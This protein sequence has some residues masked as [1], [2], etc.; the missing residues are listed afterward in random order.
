MNS[1]RLLGLIAVGLLTALPLTASA[2]TKADSIEEHH[3]I[4]AD[5][6]IDSNDWNALEADLDADGELDLAIGLPSAEA[7]RGRIV[8]LF[9]PIRDWPSLISLHAPSG[10]RHATIAGEWPGDRF[11]A[12]LAILPPAPERSKAALLVGAPGTRPPAGSDASGSIY[13][14]TMQPE[15][16]LSSLADLDGHDGTRLLAADP[17]SG[18][19]RQLL[20]IEPDGMVLGRL[21]QAPHSLR[22]DGLPSPLGASHRIGDRSNRSATPLGRLTD[23]LPA[24]QRSFSAPDVEVQGLRSGRSLRA[25]F[26][27]E[28]NQTRLILS[29]E[30]LQGSVPLIN[31][32]DGIA[33]QFV[34][35]GTSLNLDFIISDPS[36]PADQLTVQVQVDPQSPL[37]NP[38]TV[39][40]LGT[41][42]FRTLVIE[43]F[44][45]LPDGSTPVTVQVSNPLGQLT[46]APFAL[47]VIGTSV[48]EINGGLGLT[49]ETVV[50]GDTLVKFFTADDLLFFP[51]QLTYSATSSNPAL[52]PPTSI[53]LDGDGPDRVITIPTDA[54]SNGQSLITVQVSNP[55]AESTSADFLLTVG[56]PAVGPR[57]NGG[58][59]IPARSVTAGQTL[60]VAFQISDPLE[61]AASLGVSASSDDQTL[62]P[63]N[64]LQILGIGANRVLRIPTSSTATGTV[65]LTLVV[66][67]SQGLSSSASF[68][69]SILQRSRP[70]LNFNLT[71]PVETAQPGDVV[72]WNLSVGDLVDPPS[73]LRLE[74][75]SLTPALL[76]DS[77]LALFGSS[78]SRLLRATVPLGSAAGDARIGLRLTNTAGLQSTDEIELIIDVPP[79]PIINDGEPLPDQALPPGQTTEIDLPILD[80]DG[81]PGVFEVLVFSLDQ[82]VLPDEALRLIEDGDDL[83]LEIDTSLGLPGTTRIVIEARDPEGGV[84][85]TSFELTIAADLTELELESEAVD[86]QF[87]DQRFFEIRVRNRGDFPA[88][89]LDLR[90]NSDG[91]I[92]LLSTVSRASGCS[93]D[94]QNAVRCEDRVGSGWQCSGGSL[95]RRCRLESLEVDGE[96]RLLLG[97]RRG[98]DGDVLLEADASNAGTVSLGLEG[99][100]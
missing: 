26:D 44:P 81:L 12:D 72:E 99:E 63:D 21:D 66:S 6:R 3:L 94:G 97:I 7:D 9:G 18:L 46:E 73:A 68:P 84:S 25:E 32:G 40:V 8:V 83:R 45:G 20:S 58:N 70:L 74:A 64:S 71:V 56:V 78:S 55:L 53:L 62:V 35:S 93:V 86:L 10:L 67:N 47:N 29:S 60:D 49:D 22:I 13:A 92:E 15:F 91:G 82:D 100:D 95:T 5:D 19:G 42:Q 28:T 36:T 57:I 89:L 77:A 54:A 34:L 11:G 31:F 90:L 14:L 43:T 69:L 48:P 23:L 76:P 80:R 98:V 41:D 85:R 88:E 39:T 30:S 52:I 61:P 24:R 79:G 37:I 75:R 38:Q 16:D 50:A 65:N 2:T 27:S 59:G 96:A 4:L 51:D 87:G 1:V 17:V 33:D